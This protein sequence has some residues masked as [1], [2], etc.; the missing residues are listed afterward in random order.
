MDKTKPRQIL[1]IVSK[2]SSQM[3]EFVKMLSKFHGNGVKKCAPLR[4]VILSLYSS[5]SKKISR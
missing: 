2:N 4:T 3:L 5:S 1:N